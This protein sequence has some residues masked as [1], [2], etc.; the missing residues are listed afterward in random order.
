[1]SKSIDGKS[2]RDD[3]YMTTREV[4]D[5]FHVGQ[6]TVRNWANAG[7]LGE[8][9]RLPSLRMRFLRDDVVAFANKKYDITF[10]RPAK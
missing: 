10:R 5:L 3:T 8:M 6:D 1:M 2:P 9:I 7:Y 4:A